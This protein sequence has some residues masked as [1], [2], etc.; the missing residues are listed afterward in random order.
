ME[1]FGSVRRF[2]LDAKQNVE[3][4]GARWGN[5]SLRILG[6]GLHSRQYDGSSR[7]GENNRAALRAE[8]LA[9]LETIAVNKVSSGRS[10]LAFQLHF[11]KF[12]SGAFAAADKKMIAFWCQLGRWPVAIE[13]TRLPDL[14]ILSSKFRIRSGPRLKATQSIQDFPGWA[15]EIDEPVFFF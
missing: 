9:G 14:Q 1:K 12:D 4:S 15:R 10:F 8:R 5:C 11:E 6:F 2:A 3:R 7:R 13:G